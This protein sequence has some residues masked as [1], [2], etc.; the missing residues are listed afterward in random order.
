MNIIKKGGIMDKE[1]LIEKGYKGTIE[2][3][4]NYFYYQASKR[5]SLTIEKN[6]KQYIHRNNLTGSGARTFF[7]RWVAKQK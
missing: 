4:E 1:V 3:H 5:Y 7:Y 2:Y 6:G